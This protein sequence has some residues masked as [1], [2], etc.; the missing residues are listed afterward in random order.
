MAIV[1]TPAFCLNSVVA[2]HL[3]IHEFLLCLLN[4]EF[5]E[6]ILEINL[7][8][9]NDNNRLFEPSVL[10]LAVMRRPQPNAT[11]F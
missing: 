3:T 11:L 5:I 9:K 8:R 2:I 7:I 10:E 4:M 1:A 6:Q